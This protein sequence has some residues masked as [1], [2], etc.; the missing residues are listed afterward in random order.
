MGRSG[1][2]TV[3]ELENPNWNLEKSDFFARD[4]KRIVTK[5]HG[6]FRIENY[7]P[8]RSLVLCVE[9]CIS[10]AN[11]ETGGQRFLASLEKRRNLKRSS[12]PSYF[13]PS[14]VSKNEFP[15]EDLSNN[16][17]DDGFE[18]SD[19]GLADNSSNLKLENSES[20]DVL[21]PKKFDASSDASITQPE[22]PEHQKNLQHAKSEKTFVRPS[23]IKNGIGL[24]FLLILI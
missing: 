19:V 22:S 23:P 11:F 6:L 2:K 14:S 10:L 16:D 12:V 17:S 8:R 7:F 15:I 13:S 20:D 18:K 4:F 3:S 5:F 21:L 24:F 1:E 9:K